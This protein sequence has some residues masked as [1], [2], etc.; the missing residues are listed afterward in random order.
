[1]TYLLEHPTEHTIY[2]LPIAARRRNPT[3]RAS[4]QPADGGMVRPHCS[5]GNEM[6]GSVGRLGTKL[7]GNAG[8]RR[9]ET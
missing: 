2:E 5:A 8:I 7:A 3:A 6:M 1:M 9:H 4:P